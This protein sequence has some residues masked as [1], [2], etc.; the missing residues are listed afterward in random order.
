[1]RRY[2]AHFYVLVSLL[3]RLSLGLLMGLWTICLYQIM[4]IFYWPWFFF[5]NRTVI[6]PRWTWAK[7]REHASKCTRFFFFSICRH[8]SGWLML[9]RHLGKRLFLVLIWLL[10]TLELKQLLS[11][12]CLYLRLISWAL[13]HGNVDWI[14]M[15]TI[16]GGIIFGPIDHIDVVNSNLAI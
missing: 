13:H 8:K 16:S 12:L 4:L 14:I 11:L 7:A 6:L 5:S 1:M 3:R 9:W 2:H 10:M 15:I